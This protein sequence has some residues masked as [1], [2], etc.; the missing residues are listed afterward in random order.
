MIPYRIVRT[1]GDQFRLRRTP[2][3]TLS[4]ELSYTIDEGI[5]RQMSQS[6]IKAGLKKNKRLKYLSTLLSIVFIALMVSVIMD[7][8]YFNLML[9]LVIYSSLMIIVY[10]DSG[11]A[12]LA[13]PLALSR[14]KFLGVELHWVFSSDRITISVGGKTIIID[15]EDVLGVEK[16]KYGYFIDYEKTQSASL[17]N[18][19]DRI[20]LPAN[21]LTIPSSDFDSL[22]ERSAGLKIFRFN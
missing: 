15:W 21:C 8:N 19:N 20:W 16:F 17:E 9:L 11:R 1:V 12:V 14:S 10:T 22:I 13:R 3:S 6:D 5:I 2:M 4:V 7:G 18:T